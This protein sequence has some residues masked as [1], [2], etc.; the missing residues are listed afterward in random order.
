[1]PDDLIPESDA[2]EAPQD[3]A[4]TEQQ[5]E[6]G[7]AAEAD[8]VY[9]DAVGDLL[10]SDDAEAEGED[11]QV[12]GAEDDAGDDGDAHQDAAEEPDVIDIEVTEEQMRAFQRANIEPDALIG[13]PPEQIDR[14]ATQLAQSQAEMD[15]LGAQRGR[16]DAED[17]EDADQTQAQQP[18]S[19]LNKAI[20]DAMSQ[21]ID[22]YDED[23]K[24]LG[25]VLKQ[26]VGQVGQFGEI[27]Q[28]VQA[29][30]HMADM[31]TE[32]MLSQSMAGLTANYPSID[33]PE[34]QKQVTDRFWVE[35]N[36]G[37][38]FKEG[39]T[40]YQAMQS[41]LR[42]AAKHVFANTDESSAVANLVQK[43]KQRVKSQPK[44]GRNQPDRP[45]SED[46]VYDQE[47]KKLVR[48]SA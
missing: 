20:D 48:G 16:E 33:K 28:Q 12:D 46:D 40:P 38:H 7:E 32:F 18:P 6:A 4:E 35:W 36:T 45:M 37:Q 19:D 41:A 39:T 31:M 13:L 25:D 44:A 43:N 11:E 42:D 10:S 3:A 29:Q 1:M 26:V 21:L 17:G 30:S 23:I 22:S 15:R 5:P 2:A 34:V 27:G 8:A 24:P 14:L 47:V 9:D